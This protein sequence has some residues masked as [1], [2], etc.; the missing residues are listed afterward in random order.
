MARPVAHLSTGVG[1]VVASQSPR[2][3]VLG[4]RGARSIFEAACERFVL[5]D[6]SSPYAVFI[7]T[8]RG[9]TTRLAVH[10]LR[11]MAQAAEAL[12]P[13]PRISHEIYAGMAMNEAWLAMPGDDGATVALLGLPALKARHT[14]KLPLPLRR[15]RVRFGCSF[16]SIDGAGPECFVC[17]YP[18][19][20]GRAA[21]FRADELHGATHV[22]G[23][24]WLCADG[25]LRD[26][27]DDAAP[28]PAPASGGYAF[29]GLGFGRALFAGAGGLV[30]ARDCGTGEVV[31]SA[32]VQTPPGDAWAQAGLVRRRWALVLVGQSVFLLD[33]FSGAIY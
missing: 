28:T 16:I 22:G 32:L 3:L 19:A 10:D 11:A 30:E 18:D 6:P 14:I 33:Q 21:V 5:T 4:R 17:T 25:A 26:F 9:R 23:A 13:L 2:G 15:A 1:E 29:C 24:S 8:A 12:P 31:F 20:K 27:P 7:G